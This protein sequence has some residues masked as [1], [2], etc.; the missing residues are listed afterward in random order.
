MVKRKIM[1]LDRFLFKQINAGAFV[2]TAS[3]LC[4]A[5]DA[6]ASLPQ[7][8]AATFPTQ[9][10]WLSIAFVILYLFLSKKTLPDI[11]STIDQRHQQIQE[12]NE[13]AEKTRNEAAEVQK[14]YEERLNEARKK[15]RRAFEQV[16]DDIKKETQQIMEHLKVK[17]RDDITALEKTLD[18]AKA[19]AMEDMSSIA[20]EVA[21]LAAEKIIG[22]QT[23]LKVA[24][25]VVQELNKNPKKAA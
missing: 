6:Q 14:N 17:A 11:S 19:K 5:S 16:E 20:A 8:D 1:R 9:F 22:V 23:D 21:S 10:F 4:Y 7:L 3:A 15:A 13:S 24:R 2:L 12:D 25:N 18:E